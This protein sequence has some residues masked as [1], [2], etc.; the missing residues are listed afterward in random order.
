MKNKNIKIPK[1]TD[2][3]KEVKKEILPEKIKSDDF[4][5]LTIKIDDSKVN[6]REF[7]AF[8][9]TLD[10]FYGT[11]SEEGIY[12]YA[13]KEEKQIKISEFREGSLEIVI[14]EALNQLSFDKIAM[15]WI[16]LKY[17]PTGIKLLSESALNLASTYKYVEEGRTIK[18][19]RQELE[20]KII[21]DERLPNLDER[22]VNQ[23][24]DFLEWINSKELR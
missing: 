5:E 22:K 6:I 2:V 11:L 3:I 13:H 23:L 12:R 15:I 7:G 9:T 21:E 10:K 8:L 1:P 14:Q 18:L 19:K 20:R 16:A 4:T 24:I 17:L